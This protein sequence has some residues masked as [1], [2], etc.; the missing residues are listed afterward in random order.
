MTHSD[1]VLGDGVGQ[2]GD[3]HGCH[4]GDSL[5]AGEGRGGAS[6]VPGAIATRQRGVHIG[7]GRSIVPHLHLHKKICEKNILVIFKF[8]VFVCT[9]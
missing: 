1:V 5:G 9:C 7:R 6:M 4:G 2:V 3:G 8:S